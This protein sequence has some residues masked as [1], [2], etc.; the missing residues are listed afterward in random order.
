MDDVKPTRVPGVWIIPADC[1]D[2]IA[3]M[4]RAGGSGG[5]QQGPSS[6]SGVTRA[7]CLQSSVHELQ[8]KHGHVH[9]RR[10]VL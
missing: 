3:G 8:A 10:I 5:L 2:T 9:V 7:A 6:I 1:T 4:H